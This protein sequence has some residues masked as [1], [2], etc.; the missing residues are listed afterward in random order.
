[1]TLTAETDACQQEVV[2][3]CELDAS[4]EKVWRA[5]TVPELVAEWLQV[6]HEADGVVGC[7]R[8]HDARV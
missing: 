8:N 1:M 5:L 7:R 4:P 6:P 2:V 3:E